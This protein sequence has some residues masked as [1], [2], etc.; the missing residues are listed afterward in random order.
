MRIESQGTYEVKPAYNHVGYTAA[1]VDHVYLRAGA[2]QLP[3]FSLGVIAL[4]LAV[5]LMVARRARSGLVWALAGLAAVFCVVAGL[6]SV[7][8]ATTTPREVMP[9]FLMTL[10]QMEVLTERTEDWAEELGRLP[11][12]DEWTARYGGKPIARD[13][14]GAPMAYELLGSA[15]ADGQLYRIVSEPDLDDVERVGDIWASDRRDVWVISSDF[16]G[17]DGV[18]GAGD[19]H[20]VAG[21]MLR[22]ADRDVG[23]YPHGR[24]PRP[25]EVD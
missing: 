10:H 17:P 1:A 12:V 4:M 23:T 6:A 24:E 8:N 21:R 18:F 11:T 7:A 20:F 13:G 5:M 22:M 15:G 25:V 16:L 2:T 3:V 19:D 9:Q 14:W